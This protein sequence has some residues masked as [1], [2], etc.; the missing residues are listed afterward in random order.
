MK[1][2]KS[3]RGRDCDITVKRIE[4]QDTKI[5]DVQKMSTQQKDSGMTLDEMLDQQESQ[6]N[7]TPK[8]G[9]TQDK[10]VEVDGFNF[11]I[12]VKRS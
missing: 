8:R 4:D 11:G 6:K 2:L 12:S 10:R 9:E 7:R 1:I 3:Y 5:V